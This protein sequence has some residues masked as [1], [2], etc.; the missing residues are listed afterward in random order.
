VGRDAL[1]AAVQRLPGRQRELMDALITM[2]WHSYDDLS[3]TLAMPIG[4]IGPTRVRSLERLRSD[5]D[6]VA[7]VAS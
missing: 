4:S 3:A 6:L 1:R 5:P 7:L 2:P